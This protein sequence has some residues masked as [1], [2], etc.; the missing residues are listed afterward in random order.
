MNTNH[1]LRLVFIGMKGLPP[2]LPGAGGGERE[3]DAK[4]RRLAARGH[5]ITVYCRWNFV[6][7][8]ESPYHGVRLISL[9]AIARSGIEMLTHTPLATLH[10]IVKNTGDIIS[11]H[12]MGNALFVPLARLGGKRTVV[13]MD[14][15]DWER[16]K[17]G[18]M[19]RFLLKQGATAAFRW[20]DFVYVDNRVSQQE[21]IAVSGKAP[22]V[23]TLAADI[24]DPPGHDLLPA[25]GLEPENYILFVGMLRPDKGVHLLV[26]AY[27]Q[28]E[29]AIPL[30]IVGENPD[31]PAYVQSLKDKSDGRVKYLG[32]Q[33]GTAARQLFANCLI[34]V[35]PSVMEGNSPAL[36][37]AMA[38]GRCVVVNGIPQNRETIGDAGIAF[39]AG[40]PLDLRA[41]LAELLVDRSRIAAIGQQ[42]QARIRDV[43]NWERVV[44]E[45]ERMYGDLA[46]KRN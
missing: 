46:Q 22:E 11:Y 1:P 20:A 37:S 5:E 12:G 10:A 7:H 23:I 9:P 13:Y 8:P 2:D 3:T 16:P 35:Q 15:I 18:R 27:S 25:L 24:W 33:Y 32:Y 6:R 41:R 34:Y 45:L 36:M 26:E 28:L 43:Y 44:D 30:V 40:N 31:D 29:T 39:E 19:A 21:F 38:C 14:G 17:W 42:A 4:A